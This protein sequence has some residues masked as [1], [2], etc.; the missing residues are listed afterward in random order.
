M[1]SD[2]P[3][4][5]PSMKGRK[6][7]LIGVGVNLI[8][9]IC[10]LV[11]GIIGHSYALVA[12]AIESTADV[13]SSLIVWCGLR[14]ASTPRD[15]S[16]PYGHGKAEPL[17]G[18][19]VALFLIFAAGFIGVQSLNG[20]RLAQ[21][22]SPSPFTLAV[23]VGVILTKELLFRYV[24]TIGEDI[25]S[26]AVKTDA[27]HHRSDAITSA[28]AF[29]GITVA[30]IGGPAY[31]AADDWAALAAA[32]II[33]F[34]GYRLFLPALH[35]VMDAAPAAAMEMDVRRIAAVV[36]GVAGLEKCF[37]RK[38]GFEYY[39]DIHVEV[40]GDLTVWR[41][42]D[43]AHEVKA[44]IRGANPRVADV[45]VHIEPRGVKHE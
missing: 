10:K 31:A 16:H 40:D 8:L 44:A 43:I 41:G 6:S 42:H 9:A 12:D 25:N 33:A 34:N 18:M 3:N 30:V 20:L 13:F 7:A 39:V 28:A 11:A 32:T 15:A 19:A 37:I 23:L 36:P 35:E 26:T 24:V 4:Q 45:L 27:W 14:I 2:A 38:M 5:H 17:A 1:S 21:H 22:V 29:V